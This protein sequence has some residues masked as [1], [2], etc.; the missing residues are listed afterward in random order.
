[1]P[2][3]QN[4]TPWVSASCRRG[5]G[6]RESNTEVPRVLMGPEFMRAFQIRGQQIANDRKALREWHQAFNAADRFWIEHPDWSFSRYLD[7]I[8]ASN[9]HSPPTTEGTN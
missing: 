6:T 1:M 2:C 9:S 8:L 5:G 4:D 7:A 3:S